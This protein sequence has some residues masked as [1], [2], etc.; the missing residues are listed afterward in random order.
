MLAVCDWYDIATNF[1]MT[2]IYNDVMEPEI[3]LKYI[4]TD[5]AFDP[6]IAKAFVEMMKKR[7]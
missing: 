4:Q 2:E 3:A 6:K 1:V 5:R 7:I